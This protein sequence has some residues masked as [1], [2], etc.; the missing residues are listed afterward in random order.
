MRL[1]D[2]CMVKQGLQGNG[3]QPQLT[4]L[5]WMTPL[6]RVFAAGCLS[7]LPLLKFLPVPVLLQAAE[8]TEYLRVPAGKSFEA[9]SIRT[10]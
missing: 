8:V 6:G 9:P 3:G 2:A 4:A 1:H 7:L 5:L 10:V